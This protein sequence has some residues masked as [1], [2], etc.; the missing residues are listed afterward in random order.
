MSEHEWMKWPVGLIGYVPPN[1]PITEALLEE[2]LEQIQK[3]VSGY[4]Y[5]LQEAVKRATEH[6]AENQIEI[7]VGWI[8][9][10][11]K[12]E[13]AAERM[14]QTMQHLEHRI[15]KLTRKAMALCQTGK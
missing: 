13:Q 6:L 12:Y 8:E 9:R 2:K 11:I 1:D 10:A 4:G 7:A 14:F 5:H 3:L 15:L